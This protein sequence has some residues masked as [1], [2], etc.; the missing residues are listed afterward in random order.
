[1]IRNR[2][3]YG[4]SVR[5]VYNCANQLAERHDAAGSIEKFT[6]D[7]L[8]RLQ[9]HCDRDGRQVHYAYNMLGSPTEISSCREHMADYSYDAF[10]N[11]KI[12]LNSLKDL[13][14]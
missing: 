13:P 8:G 12:K 5:Y 2:L 4:W 11:Q 10:G 14:R 7:I 9:G 3:S 6:Y 1:M